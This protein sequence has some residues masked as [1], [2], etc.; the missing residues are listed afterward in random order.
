MSAQPSPDRP[1]LSRSFWRD[2]RF[3]KA[4]TQVLVLVIIAAFVYI[5]ARNMVASLRKQGIALGFNFLN[6]AAGFDI[7]EMLIPYT[8][9]DTFARALQVGMLNTLVVCVAGVIL[10]T[11]LGIL[12]GLARLS[13]NFLISR[14]A[15]VFVEAMRNVPLLVLL[16]FI[17]STIFLKLPRVRQAIELPG[18]IFLSNRGVAVPWGIPT[19]SFRLYLLA[20]VLAAVAAIATGLFIRQRQRRLDRPQPM[21]ALSLLAFVATAIVSWFIMP[22]SPLSLD[23]PACLLY[24]SPSPRDRT[25]YRMPSSA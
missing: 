10:S 23:F 15:R 25:R 22:Q 13:E 3:I 18:S 8:S 14:L 16:I 9:T 7:G 5:L 19:A 1:A 2:E 12:V 21:I 24:T 20:L 6:D 4:A 17:Y 11:L